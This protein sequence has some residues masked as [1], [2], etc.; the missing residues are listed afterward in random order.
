MRKC[1]T[2]FLALILFCASVRAQKESPYKILFAITGDIM[3]FTVDNLDNVYVLNASDQI[4][5]YN[6]AGDSVAVFNNIK[7]FGKVYMIDASNP[8]KVLI[9][10]K[11]FSTIVVLDRLLSVRNTIDLRKLNNFNVN[12]IGQSYDNN[13]W[14][15]DENDSK[16]KKLNDDGKILTETSDFRLLFG[17][18]PMIRSIC[19][20]DGFVYLYDPLQAVFVFDYYGSVRN[21]IAINN[22]E[23][24]KVAEKFIFGSNGDSLHRYSISTFFTE[25]HKL[26]SVLKNSIK[27]NFTSRRLYALKKDFLEIYGFQ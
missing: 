5:K 22:W 21:K 7:K 19:D 4:K 3:D 13:I 25:E 14:L 12:A 26:P 27:L 16:L 24:F 1:L 18:A 8:L 10:Y 11:D 17:Q 15:Y 9:Y 6:S 23:N 2:I 20:Q